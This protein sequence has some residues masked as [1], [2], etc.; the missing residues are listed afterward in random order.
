MEHPSLMGN[1]HFV[2]MMNF[3]PQ[4]DPI[5]FCELIPCVENDDY[6]NA[7]HLLESM[8]M[9]EP[10]RRITTKKALEHPLFSDLDKKE[11]AKMMKFN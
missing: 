2:Q 9:I 5:D 7:L 8:L 3:L 11:I 4:W 10:T 6:R 1:P